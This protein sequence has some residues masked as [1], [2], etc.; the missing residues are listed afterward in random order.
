MT[1][2]RVAVVGSFV[3]DLAFKVPLFPA[4]G[5]TRIGT[6]FTGPG[7]KGSNQAVACHRQN[8]PT[9]FIGAIGEDLFGNGY[10]E[11]ASREKLPVEL[12]RT[13][14]ATGAASVVINQEAQNLIVVALG[15]N[16]DLSPLHVLSALNR[17]ENLSVI[18]LQ[19]ESNLEATKAAL[20]HAQKRG[21]ISILN[22]APINPG[23]TSELLAL[24]DIITPNETEAAF[25]AKHVTGEER[26]IDVTALDDETIIALC[27]RFPSST[28]LITLGANGS[29]LYQAST[30]HPNSKY[31]QKEDFVRIPALPGVT[32][33]DT[34]GAGDAFNGGFAAGL[35]HFD[36]DIKRA[37]KYATVVAGLSTQREGTSPAMPTRAE[38]ERHADFF[39]E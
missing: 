20:E 26:H 32:P 24:A 6:F 38:V 21:A 4:P 1:A 22:P 23:L 5:E 13:T 31:T 16:D 36:G 33:V 18:L 34:T 2:A 12:Q 39:K 15:A 28:T 8:A 14:T 29:L 25:L 37:I 17:Q 30:P 10:A 27:K 3:Q 19:A 35:V 7:G 9:V 11:W